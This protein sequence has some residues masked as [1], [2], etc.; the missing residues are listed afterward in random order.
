MRFR[1]SRDEEA[2]LT[3]EVYPLLLHRHFTK[4]LTAAG[5]APLL[6]VQNTLVEFTRACEHGTPRDG[7]RS[8][9]S[10]RSAVA[11][12]DCAPHAVGGVQTLQMRE[13]LSRG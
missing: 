6:Q 1:D 8:R 2:M 11:F 13:S 7:R 10:S 12:I 4:V 3:T 5:S 9:F